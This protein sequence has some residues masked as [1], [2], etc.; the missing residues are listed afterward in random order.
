MSNTRRESL[1]NVVANVACVN[2]ACGVRPLDCLFGSIS[3][4][5][6]LSTYPSPKSTL[7]L[8]SHS[9]QNVALGEG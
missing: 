1:V 5:G 6:K 3:V 4:S 7:T 8:T 9:G 2:V